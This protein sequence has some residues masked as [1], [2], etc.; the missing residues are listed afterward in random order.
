MSDFAVPDSLH[1]PAP[2]RG[3]SVARHADSIAASAATVLAGLIDGAADEHPFPHRL[4]TACLD[5][6][7]YAALAE[8]FPSAKQ[9][10]RDDSHDGNH[11]FRL[12]S[13]DVLANRAIDSA[14][15]AFVTDH[16]SQAFWNQI[17]GAF[18]EQLLAAHPAIERTVG[19]PIDRWRAVRRQSGQRGD[20][21]LE[22]QL[23]I[24]TP[25]IGKASAVKGPH[26]DHS[27]K[28]WT[29]LLYLRLP[30]DDT[31]GGDLQLHAPTRDFRFD[32]H[33]APRRAL[34]VER[35]VA[36]RA[37]S[38]IGFVN[39]PRAIHSVTP[40]QPSPHVRRYV[41]FVAEVDG[42][43][44]RLPQMASLQRALFRL[45]HRQATR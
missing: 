5:A 23:V 25:G 40:R 36:Y 18:G 45:L 1:G 21:T 39:G 13:S 29:G 30:E 27:S 2:L 6:S 44:F 35:T 33:Q 17:V 10:G 24:N 12:A 11:V 28:L 38:F 19:R 7:H 42:V 14:W 20:V 37:N 22:C 15:H 3:P 8:R 32:A 9:F 34:R 31:P 41:D 16:T 26:V 4:A 43:A